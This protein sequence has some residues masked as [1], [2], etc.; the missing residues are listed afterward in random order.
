VT[1]VA[2]DLNE[3]PERRDSVVFVRR[4]GSEF[5]KPP[6]RQIAGS[7]LNQQLGLLKANRER[8]VHGGLLSAFS[9]LLPAFGVASSQLQ[10][11]VRRPL[12]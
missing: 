2:L 1:R 11:T 10:A 6:R 12:C 3:T 5:L 8:A 9:R 7:G 4:I